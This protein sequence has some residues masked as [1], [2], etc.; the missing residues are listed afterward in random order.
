MAA[1]IG[2]DDPWVM[3]ATSSAVRLTPLRML[4]DVDRL[5]LTKDGIVLKLTDLGRVDRDPGVC[6]G[7]EVTPIRGRSEIVLLLPTMLISTVA[8]LGALS[9]SSEHEYSCGF[10]PEDWLKTWPHFV[11]TDGYDE[12]GDL[13]ASHAR[14]LSYVPSVM[15][16]RYVVGFVAS[17]HRIAGS[18]CAPVAATE[19]GE[20]RWSERGSRST[21]APASVNARSQRRSV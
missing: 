21:T 18:N 9:R 4:S 2:K 14:N 15:R 13:M 1:S 16:R 11:E 17:D 10:A 8:S 3:A 20:P 7:G 12:A 19:D 6:V 5:E